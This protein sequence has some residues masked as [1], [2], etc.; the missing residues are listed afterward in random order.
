MKRTLVAVGGALLALLQPVLGAQTERGASPTVVR[1]QG[2]PRALDGP[3]YPA[4]YVV[5]E[6]SGDGPM[7]V[8]HYQRVMLLDSP[9]R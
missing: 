2:S 7:R 8:V 9:S 5:V 4:H 6:A 3:R 1:P